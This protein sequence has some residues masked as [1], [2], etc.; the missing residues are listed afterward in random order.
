MA[1]VDRPWLVGRGHRGQRHRHRASEIRPACLK[2]VVYVKLN[3]LADALP[4]RLGD[5]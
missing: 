2:L 3:L 5:R 1:R 4:N